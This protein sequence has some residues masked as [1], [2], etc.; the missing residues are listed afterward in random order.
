[1]RRSIA[2]SCCLAGMMMLTACAGEPENSGIKDERVSVEGRPHVGSS[3]TALED[4]ITDDPGSSRPCDLDF[5]NRQAVVV[6]EP[7][8]VE[9][10]S[11]HANLVLDLSSSTRE[12]VQVTVSLNGEV[13]LDVRTPA[14][15]AE[16]SHSPVYSHEFRLP[17]DNAQVTVVTDQGQRRSISVPLDGPTRWV[18]IQPQ[19]GF[20]LSLDVF[21]EE[22]AWG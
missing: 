6:S 19:D 8:L 21:N 22:P 4:V 13:A 7:Q 9:V 20:P 3:D 14:V 15:P 2:A 11:D 5:L 10:S 16:C 18:V 12:P 1:M 17:V